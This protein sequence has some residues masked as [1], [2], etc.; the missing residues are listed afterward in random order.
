MTNPSGTLLASAGRGIS[1]AAGIVASEGTA[2]LQADGSI[3]L[4]T[5]T[6]QDS[7]DAIRDTRNFTRF[8]QSQD[9]GS[10][11][12]AA[13]ALSLAAG[14]IVDVEVREIRDDKRLPQAQAETDIRAASGLQLIFPEALTYRLLPFGF[15]LSSSIDPV[16]TTRRSA[17]KT[18]VKI[19]AVLGGLR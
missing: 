9:I 18:T 8:G 1:V 13:G 15:T 6:T 12:S 5:L 17:S 2:R 10:Q 3:N 11:I 7:V 16:L 4:G 14:D 19:I